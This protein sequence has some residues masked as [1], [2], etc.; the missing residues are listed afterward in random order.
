MRVL[1]IEDDLKMSRLIRE[2]LE[3]SGHAVE[4]EQAGPRGVDRSVA[5]PFDAIVLDVMLPGMDGFETCRRIRQRGIWTPILMLTARDSVDDRVAGLDAGSDDYLVKPFSFAELLARLRALDRRGDARGTDI[6]AVGN[7]RLDRSERRV[8]RDE[9]EVELTRREFD[10]LDALMQSP[11]RA[12]ERHEL[13]DRAWADDLDT[14]SNVVD[15][16]IRYLRNKIDRPFDAN[17]IETVRG[18]GYRIKATPNA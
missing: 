12:F 14:Q 5:Q 9:H 2:G 16:Y 13:L 10:L 11:G 1:V 8:W 3:L 17:S 6:I 15:Q 18:V 4:C 7:L